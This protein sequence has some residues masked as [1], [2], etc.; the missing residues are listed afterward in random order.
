MTTSILISAVAIPTSTPTIISTPALTFI[1]TLAPTSIS[2][3]TLISISTSV[4]TSLSTSTLTFTTLIVSAPALAEL[5]L[6][7][8]PEMAALSP[9]TCIPTEP[10]V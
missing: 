3:L 7:P 8:T 6:S 10:Q 5:T 1:L 9:A 4:P 2:T